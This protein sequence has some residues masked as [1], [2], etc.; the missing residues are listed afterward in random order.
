LSTAHIDS[1]TRRCHTGSTTTTGRDRTARSET[2][3][4]SAAF[5]TSVGRTSRPPL[6]V[7]L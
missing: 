5:T 1:A 3:H 2:G 7:A 4:R 6:R